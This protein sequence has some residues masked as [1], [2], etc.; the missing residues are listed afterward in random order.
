MFKNNWFIDIGNSSL[1]M[2]SQQGQKLEYEGSYSDGDIP[3]I[4]RKITL[5]GGKFNKNV[6]IVSVVPKIERNLIRKLASLKGVGIYRAGHNLPLKVKNAYR[7][8]KKLGLDRQVN[9]YGALKLFKPPFLIFDFGSAT[10]VD[11]VDG[12][13]CFQGG[14]ICLGAGNG[15][16]AL[17]E[18]TALLPKVGLRNI[19]ALYG[20][21]TRSGMLAGAV[22]GHAAMVDGLIQKFRGRYG[23]G[24]KTIGTGGLADIIFSR[25]D[26]LDYRDPLLTLRSL[27]RLFADFQQNK[28]KRR[29]ND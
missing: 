5:G 25:S 22:Q 7:Q 3:R 21:D 17:H 28:K 19:K 20:Q 9:V 11:Y 23:S 15:L 27:S 18:K 24:I 26:L 14:L 13:G 29:K 8:P 12:K 4:V 10:T 1:A 2:A 6:I 16:Q